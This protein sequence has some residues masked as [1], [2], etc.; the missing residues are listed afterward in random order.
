MFKK[1]RHTHTHTKHKHI[2]RQN[3]KE[4][5]KTQK[6]KINQKSDAR[7]TGLK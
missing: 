6:G 3:G 7:L 2:E 4:G 5:K 1:E